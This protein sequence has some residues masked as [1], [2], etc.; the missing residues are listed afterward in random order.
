MLMPIRNNIPQEPIFH[1]SEII[2]NSNGRILNADQE[3]CEILN[4]KSHKGITNSIILDYI[5]EEDKKTA[6]NAFIDVF[7]GKKAGKLFEIKMIDSTK[8]EIEVTLNF[9]P[10]KGS[11]GEKS[12]LLIRKKM[13]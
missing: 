10:I 6:V 5:V 12:T 8:T 7:Y 1:T 2:V 3:F 13:F 11:N 9:F 4:C